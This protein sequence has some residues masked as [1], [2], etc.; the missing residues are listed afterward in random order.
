MTDNRP[1]ERVIAEWEGWLCFEEKRGEHTFHVCFSPDSRHSTEPWKRC[2]NWEREKERY[3]ELAWGEF[4]PSLQP[5]PMLPRYATDA[6]LWPGIME[7]VP[8]G[9][10]LAWRFEWFLAHNHQR[11]YSIHAGASLLRLGPEAWTRA[12]AQ[13]IRETEVG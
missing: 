4:D 9:E 13:A 3:R 11:E 10:R 7:M 1:D 12:L 6:N 2:Q 5:L 8:D